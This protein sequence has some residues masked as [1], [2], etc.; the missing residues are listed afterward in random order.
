ML[1]NLLK[2]AAH[3]AISPITIAADVV[4][5]PVRAMD[6]SRGFNEPFFNATSK[7]LR[8]AMENIEEAADA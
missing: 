1:G 6:Y 4:S 2:A 7:T 8:K 5:A 3:V